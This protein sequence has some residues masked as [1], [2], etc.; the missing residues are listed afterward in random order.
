MYEVSGS[1]SAE[2]ID[3]V[4]KDKAGGVVVGQKQSI[5][6][7]RKFLLKSINGF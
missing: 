7:H 6:F 1:D 3:E 2:S 4:D 5:L